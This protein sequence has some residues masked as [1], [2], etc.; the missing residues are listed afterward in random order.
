MSSTP[1]RSRERGWLIGWMIATLLLVCFVVITQTFNLDSVM[2]SISAVFLVVMAV[3]YS[4]HLRTDRWMITFGAVITYT[5][6]VTS[7]MIT[8]WILHSLALVL[9]LVMQ[10]KWAWKTLIRWLSGS[11]WCSA[12]AATGYT[13]VHL[14]DDKLTMYLPS[15]A[16]YADDVSYLLVYVVVLYGLRSVDQYFHEPWSDPVIFPNWKWE[17]FTLFLIPPFAL[18]MHSFAAEGDQ[19]A[20][21]YLIIPLIAMGYIFYLYANME[22]MQ[23]QLTTI[24]DLSYAFSAE[25]KMDKALAAFYEGLQRVIPFQSVYLYEL[26]EDRQTLQIIHSS[27]QD[28]EVEGGP[29]QLKM[30]EPLVYPFT[31]KKLQSFKKTFQIHLEQHEKISI[32]PMAWNRVIRGFVVIAHSRGSDLK[33]RKRV[34]AEILIRQVTVAIY[35]SKRYEMSKQ[36]SR[37]DELTGLVNQRHFETRLY[38][39]LQIAAQTGRQFSVLLMDIDFFKKVN[40]TYGHLAGNVVLKGIADILKSLTG[41]DDTV[42]RYGG[43]EF[44]VILHGMDARRAAWAAESIRVEVENTTF[45]VRQDLH[46]EP[47]SVTVTPAGEI[48]EPH[49]TEHSSSIEGATTIDDPDAVPVQVT[50]SIGL[51]T[52]PDH[53]EDAHGLIRLADRAMYVGAKQAGRNR[54]AVYRK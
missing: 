22:D 26:D 8:E 14:A 5:I 23:I 52:F 41:K 25:L 34:L 30:D 31:S 1:I 15:F 44:C 10:R 35:N 36:K 49:V 54:V 29:I 40:D 51:A 16:P 9:V 21:I 7:G 45:W 33:G 46:E 17:T 24:H 47:S 27:S 42:S 12:A 20:I 3:V 38:Q 13:M 19:L 4:F 2:S 48:E 39:E 28:D 18:L 37:E 43:E 50:I 53:A 6:F 11:L 32:F